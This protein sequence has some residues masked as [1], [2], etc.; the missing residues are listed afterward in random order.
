[1][2]KSS[3]V[4]RQPSA[5]KG[6]TLIELLV[7][8]SIIAILSAIGI[9]TY[10]S[11]Q[12]SARDARRKQDSKALQTAVTLYYQQNRKYPGHDG[13]WY[14]SNNA[15]PWLTSIDYNYINLMPI[16]PLNTGTN[17]LPN[18]TSYLY[19]YRGCG[20]NDGSGFNTSG[21]VLVA[22]LE[23]ANDPDRDEVKH[24]TYCNGTSTSFGAK[25]YV[26]GN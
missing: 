21:F 26:V 1:M 14:K 6:F 13:V 16:D 23:N 10:S 11:A 2:R 12:V 19:Y 3:A 8:I 18:N 20:A 25:T 22:L 17:A 9:V 7:T 4:S 15:A 24:Y 5:L